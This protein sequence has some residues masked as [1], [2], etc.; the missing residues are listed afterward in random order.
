M[1]V[2]LA[3]WTQAIVSAWSDDG[4]IHSSNHTEAA[5]P[6][7][8][9]EASDCRRDDFPHLEAGCLQAEVQF[10]FGK[11]FELFAQQDLVPC[12]V[13]RQFVIGNHKCPDLVRRQVA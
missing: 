12:R 9:G 1:E 3:M 11:S 8:G 5:V 13:L 2:M 7:F 4:H 6:A 10:N